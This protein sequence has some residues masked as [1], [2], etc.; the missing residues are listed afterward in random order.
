[1]AKFGGLVVKKDNLVIV[2]VHPG[3]SVLRKSFGAERKKTFGEALSR[4]RK[5][6]KVTFRSIVQMHVLKNAKRNYPWVL[7]RRTTFS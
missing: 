2:W 7:Y 6:Q 1:M 3:P 4:K 5:N